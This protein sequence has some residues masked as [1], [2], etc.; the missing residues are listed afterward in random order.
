MSGYNYP[1]SL[2]TKRN[3]RGYQMMI[4]VK[5]NLKSIC[6]LKRCIHCMSQTVIL[7]YQPLFLH[8]EVQ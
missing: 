3:N 5:R 8:F 1:V 7:E 6:E 4:Q 2:L